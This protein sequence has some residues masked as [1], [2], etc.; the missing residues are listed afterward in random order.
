MAGSLKTLILY[1]PTSARVLYC[2]LHWCTVQA[3]FLKLS[4]LPLDHSYNRVSGLIVANVCPKGS[5][6]WE[7]SGEAWPRNNNPPLYWDH[8][9]MNHRR[10]TRV[11]FFWMISTPTPTG[12]H[13]GSHTNKV[14]IFHWGATLF[15]LWSA[16]EVLSKQILIIVIVC[17]VLWVCRW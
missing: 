3:G 4:W 6:P 10:I 7:K 14:I 15:F 12:Q 5:E 11:Y 8:G 13:P 2:V 17:K 16:A 1:N 9:E